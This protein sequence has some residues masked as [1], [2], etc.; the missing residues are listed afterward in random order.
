[1]YREHC[2]HGKRLAGGSHSP[3]AGGELEG[4]TGRWGLG[5]LEGLQVLDCESTAVHS[6]GNTD[7][8]G[9]KGGLVR[10]PTV[11]ITA[12]P[13]VCGGHPHLRGPRAAAA[14]ADLHD[15]RACPQRGGPQRQE[16]ARHSPHHRSVPQASLSGSHVATVTHPVLL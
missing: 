6:G 8:P 10:E 13:Q 15:L 1:M 16:R 2:V 14:P 3:L 12:S 9:L 11:T 4:F 7:D 5:D